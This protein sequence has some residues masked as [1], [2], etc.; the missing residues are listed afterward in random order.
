MRTLDRYIIRTFLVSLG[1]WF[2]I[3][4]TLRILLDLFANMDE[5]TEGLDT[6]QG[7][8]GGLLFFL[9]TILT[10]YAYQSFAYI[11]ELWGV[12]LVLGACFA[13][14]WL[15]YTNELTAT[16]ASGISLHRVA[17]PIILC[18]MALNAL[19]ILDQEFV[20]PNIREQLVLD[21]DNLQEQQKE[22]F[23]VRFLT[24]SDQS[25]WW[26]ADYDP[27]EQVLA[28]PLVILRDTQYRYLADFR[29]RRA[30]PGRVG[31]RR[32]WIAVDAELQRKEGPNNVPWRS[33]QR[34]DR[35]Y[36]LLTPNRL[37]DNARPAYRK[38][39]QGRDIPPG[40]SIQV[41]N[42][43]GYDPHFGMKLRADA[44]VPTRWNGR[45]V[46]EGELIHPFFEFRTSDD[47]LLAT[48]LAD[49][50]VWFPAGGLHESYWRLEG[51]RLFYETDLTD[52]DLELRQDRQWI[53]YLS[54]AEL[55]SLLRL[56]NMPDI[57]T[58][59]LTKYIRFADPLNS[60]VMLLLGTSLI[61]SRD[62]KVWM[63]IVLC[64]AVVGTFF[65]SVFVLRYMD[66]PPFLAAFLPA[67]LAGPVSVLMLDSIKT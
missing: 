53:E 1:A 12:I 34:S 15:N 43:E 11:K 6:V 32:G 55:S 64:I 14:A 39:H 29:A 5:F 20:I 9:K 33:T 52:R 19:V 50:A 61:L 44:F 24:D 22:R 18:A 31:R 47:R 2:L 3:I 57:Q 40:A 65:L 45:T 54:S 35:I 51:G 13:V 25:V 49:K 59:Q 10:Y 37:L 46:V 28:W 23:Q 36:S 56:R 42:C 48:I 21:P 30:Q 41:Q 26:S 58:V 4:M 63:S 17:A 62:R 8:A 38:A 7:Q 60:L 27:T 67:L 16:L 66:I